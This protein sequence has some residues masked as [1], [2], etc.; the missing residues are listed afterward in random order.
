MENRKK[1]LPKYQE[2][3]HRYLAGLDILRVLTYKMPYG[4]IVTY[5][6]LY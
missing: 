4:E 2:S 3:Q 6:T 5:T 1:I